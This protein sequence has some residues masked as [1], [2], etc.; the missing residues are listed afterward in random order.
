MKTDEEIKIEGTKALIHAM[1]PVEAERYIAL[2]AQGKFDYTAWRRKILPEGSVQEISS[3]AMQFVKE[4][5]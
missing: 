5:T 2:M 4:E 3:A 1:G